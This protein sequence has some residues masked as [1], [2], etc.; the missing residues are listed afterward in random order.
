MKQV[1]DQA[2]VLIFPHKKW[3]NQCRSSAVFTLK[4]M[5]NAFVLSSLRRLNP[6]SQ[7]NLLTKSWLFN[8][9]TIFC[10]PG[11]HL[12]KHQKN[13]HHLIPAFSPVHK[14]RKFSAVFG[15]VSWL[16]SRGHGVGVFNDKVLAPSQ[17]VGLG[18]F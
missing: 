7:T 8:R 3:I 15:T 9:K 14:A 17:V 2:E 6:L 18:D 5:I 11:N 1:M 13:G 10:S 16:A 4:R 12:S